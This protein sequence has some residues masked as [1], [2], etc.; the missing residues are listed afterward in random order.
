[1]GHIKRS[2]SIFL[3]LFITL[4]LKA[5]QLKIGD[6]ELVYLNVNIPSNGWITHANWSTNVVGLTCFDAGT[7]GTGIRVDGYWSGTATLSCSYSYSYYGFD[8][9][10][11]VGSSRKSWGFTC[12]GYQIVLTP[13]SLTLDKGQSEILQFEVVG[14]S[15]GKLPA[16]WESSDTKIAAVYSSG[17]Y[18][19][20]VVARSPG[21]CTITCY[22]YMGEPVICNV[23][24]NTFPPTS[25]SITPTSAEV[26]ED[27][28]IN[29]TCSLLP[30]GA[31]AN[32]TWKS[33]DESIATV[34]NGTVKGVKAGKTWIT[35][36]TDNG[37]KA[38]SEITVLEGYKNPRGPV[39]KSLKGN[40]T[41]E[42][43]YLITSAA[44]L[45]FLSDDVNSGNDYNGKYFKQTADIEIIPLRYD[46]PE[47]RNMEYWIPI[48]ST[49]E[50]RFCGHYDG[51][52]H[53]I[54]GINITENEDIYGDVEINNNTYVGL[55]GYAGLW[56]DKP[57]SII[58]LRLKNFLIDQET[59][60]AAGIVGDIYGF[61]SGPSG[62][63]ILENC[64]TLDGYIRGKD[65]AGIANYS[66]HGYIKNC[67]NSASVMSVDEKIDKYASAA[68]IVNDARNSIMNCVN[69][70]K[71]SG[72][73][74][75]GIASYCDGFKVENCCNAG[76]IFSSDDF[77]AGIV[78]TNVITESKLTIANCVNYGN[79]Q[80]S[81]GDG[82]ASIYNKN[83]YKYRHI[84]L[85]N[86]FYLSEY[87]LCVQ[88]YQIETHNNHAVS[89]E[90]M[91]SAATIEALNNH[92]NTE[93]SKW[94]SGPDGLPTFDWYVELCA[95]IDE[96]KMDP[97]PDSFATLPKDAVITVYSLTG[98]QVYTGSKENLPSLHK[99]IYLIRHKSQ[100]FKIII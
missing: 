78:A 89:M 67:S 25:I 5:T 45:R 64:H 37:L 61:I 29:L 26:K 11:H 30:S 90:E 10:I 34:S 57:S 20:E 59:R 99:G 56:S 12:Q 93:Y 50:H 75:S 46:N 80:S 52:N 51:D 65:A 77:C 86:N 14:G 1:M 27:Q 23:K 22:S 53:F 84:Y 79:L 6:V 88:K 47:F 70:G 76:E 16:N 85:E 32:L 81:T 96:I 2:I 42:S 13:K 41:K 92:D 68:G 74:A 35:V 60:Y 94:V 83:S 100:T 8:G 9:N 54:S 21:N 17:D 28:T 39:S 15:K 3:F 91:K 40:G 98:E 36:E 33:Q 18:T 71:I 97:Q 66:S 7:W 72:V 49:R 48:G 44:D 62:S 43:P 63:T 31:S 4:G 82:I 69:M 19:A 95:G 24:V 55:F 73:K 87:E 38:R 58:N